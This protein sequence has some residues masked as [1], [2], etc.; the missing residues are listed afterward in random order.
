MERGR[1]GRKLGRQSWRKRN[2]EK[3]ERDGERKKEEIE[4]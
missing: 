3:K 4:G 2:K 1:K